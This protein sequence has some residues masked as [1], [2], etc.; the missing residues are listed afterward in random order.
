[1]YF[2]N[3]NILVSQCAHRTDDLVCYVGLKMTD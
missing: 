1:M 3:V 2:I